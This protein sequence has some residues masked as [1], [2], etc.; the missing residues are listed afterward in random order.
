MKTVLVGV[1]DSFAL[2]CDLCG[3]NK[4][5]SFARRHFG[6]SF[7]SVHS[8]KVNFSQASEAALNDQI[9]LELAASYAYLS[10]S[11][12]LDRDGVAIPGLSKYCRQMSEE[13]RGHALLLQDY[14]NRRGGKV[15]FKPV[16]PPSEDGDW[17]SPMAILEKMFSLEKRVNEALLGVHKVSED[18]KD[19]QMSDFIEN[20]FLE[21]QV[22][23][24]KEICDM[25]VQLER[26]GSTG[27]GLYLWDQDLLRKRSK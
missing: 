4:A 21:E 6:M 9:N 16:S 10:M 25:I 19:P 13:E 7:S 5:K 1:R 3:A 23:S 27:L 26:A 14:I 18:E 11:A 24:I 12:W 20:T 22:E 8:S 17:E 2:R 15:S